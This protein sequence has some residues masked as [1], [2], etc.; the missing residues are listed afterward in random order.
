[1]VAAGEGPSPGPRARLSQGRVKTMFFH[2]T[3]PRSGLLTYYI[4]DAQNHPIDRATRID[5]RISTPG[6]R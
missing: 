3:L 6:P 1:M 2:F 5:N 4:E